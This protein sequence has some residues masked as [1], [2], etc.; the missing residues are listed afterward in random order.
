LVL[1]SE[2]AS[3][4]LKDDGLDKVNKAILLAL[5]DE[6]FSSVLAARQIAR[7]ICVTKGTAYRR[8]VDSLHF[9]VRHQTPSLGSS[10]ALRKSEG[11]S[12]RVVNATMQSPAAHPASRIG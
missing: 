5:F 7:R 12:S 11:K 3:S 8:L 2:E 1:N 6:P 4:S 10:Q 9:T